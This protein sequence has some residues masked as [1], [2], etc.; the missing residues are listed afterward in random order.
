MQTLTRTVEVTVRRE[1][2]TVDYDDEFAPDGRTPGPSP[3]I[4]DEPPLDRAPLVIVLHEEVPHVVL[5]TVPYEVATARITRVVSEQLVGTQ[6]AH[7]RVA[8][9][10]TPGVRVPSGIDPCT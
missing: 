3:Q 2:L 9:D 5:E 8:L 10:T 1:V 7:E 4:V 6:L